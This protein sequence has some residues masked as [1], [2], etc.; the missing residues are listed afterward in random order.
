MYSAE[1]LP[2]FVDEYL[3]YLYEINPTP[4][5]FDGVHA[6]TGFHPL[7]QAIVALVAFGPFDPSTLTFAVAAANLACLAAAVAIVALAFRRRGLLPAYGR[8]SCSSPSP[9]RISSR[10]R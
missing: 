8:W 5:T 9:T 3:A 6:T 7:W 2:H 1:P 4:A 10:P